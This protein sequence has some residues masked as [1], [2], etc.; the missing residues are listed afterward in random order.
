[1]IGKR[2]SEIGANDCVFSIAAVDGVTGKRGG[3]AEV[4]QTEV[5]IPASAIRSSHPGNADACA[6][7]KFLGSAGRISSYNFADNLM[8]G[9]DSWAT[10]WQVAFDDMQIGAANSTRTHP[11]QNLTLLRL[12][13]CHLANP[14]RALPNFLR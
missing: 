13:R 8:S 9:D 11:Y 10:G 7:R 12:R 5:T 3:I 6:D 1:L 2:K 14:K 4:L